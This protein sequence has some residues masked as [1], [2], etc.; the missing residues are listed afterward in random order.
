[1]DYRL[2]TFFE[3]GMID[4]F[5]GNTYIW[6]NSDKKNICKLVRLNKDDDNIYGLKFREN[7]LDE[8]ER[9]EFIERDL[10]SDYNLISINS[11][12]L[13]IG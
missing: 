12:P 11:E 9:I 3:G 13:I 8:G 6:A 10:M 7:D 4:S 1:M 2:R 5:L